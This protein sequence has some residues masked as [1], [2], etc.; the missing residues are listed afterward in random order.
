MLED[1]YKNEIVNAWVEDN[2]PIDLIE[3]RYKN[4]SSVVDGM[5]DFV[6]SFSYYYTIRRDYG[7]DRKYTMIEMH[8]LTDIYDNENITVSA[9]AKKW[10]RT[11]SAISQIVHRL[12]K[13]GLVYKEVNESDGKVFFL[14][15]TEKAKET[16]LK[17]KAYDNKDNVKTR[18]KLLE[19]F[20]VDEM[21]A[22]DKILKAYTRIL[23]KNNS[24]NK[25]L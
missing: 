4:I 8:I 10:N 18:K 19:S 1:I 2:E 17:H 9:L 20:T 24:K 13:W 12:I 22:F 25:P 7:T 23:E 3:K 16:V 11:S 15:T 14:R 21:V 6:L 5:Y